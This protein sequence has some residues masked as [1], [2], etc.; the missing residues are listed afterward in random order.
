MRV[1]ENTSQLEF[2]DDGEAEEFEVETICDNAVYAKESKSSQIPGLYY[3][4]S[5]KDCPE[6]ENTWKPALAIQHLRRLISTFHKENP[7]KPSAT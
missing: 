1:D 6:E 3:I 4:I 5:W 2:K 7:D